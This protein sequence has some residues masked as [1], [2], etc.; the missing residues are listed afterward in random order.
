ML[1]S[2]DS[3]R[4]I[5][6]KVLA[7]ADESLVLKFQ[8]RHG[9]SRLELCLESIVKAKRAEM[10]VSIIY[11]GGETASSRLPLLLFVRADFMRPD[12]WT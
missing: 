6:F 8:T 3:G 5:C 1:C 12:L 10:E 11:D 4:K 9:S 2:G 7:V